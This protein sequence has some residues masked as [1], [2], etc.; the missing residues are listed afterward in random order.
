MTDM[1]PRFFLKFLA[2]DVHPLRRCETPLRLQESV[3]SWR[4]I[5]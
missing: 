1:P 4:T 3:W 2:A 5:I